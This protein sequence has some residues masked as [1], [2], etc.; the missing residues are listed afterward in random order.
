VLG[1]VRESE[2]RKVGELLEYVFD[3]EVLK[4]GDNQGEH[5]V[6]GGLELFLD[7][8]ETSL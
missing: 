8:I 4:L 7:F 5:F 2:I 6:T 3:V 1:A